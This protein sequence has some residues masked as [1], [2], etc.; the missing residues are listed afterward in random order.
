MGEKRRKT[1]TKTKKSN[2]KN[3]TKVKYTKESVNLM[4]KKK[5]HPPHMNQKLMPPK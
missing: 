2:P 4:K 3:N 1:E 5:L